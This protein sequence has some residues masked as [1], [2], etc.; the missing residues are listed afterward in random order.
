MFKNSLIA[1]S[2][3]RVLGVN[4]SVLIGCAFTGTL[5][6][7]VAGAQTALE[8]TCSSG[9]VCRENSTMLPL[10]ALPRPYSPMYKS[11]EVKEGNILTANVKPFSPVYVFAR[12]NV[13]FSNPAEP[14]GWYQVGATVKQPL[15]WIQAKDL[16]E[17]KQALVVSYT[18][19]GASDEDKRSRVLMFDNK[20]AL[21]K[22]VAASD[23]Q[24]VAQ[25]L[26][27]QITK[28]EKPENVITAEPKEFLNIENTFY[29]LPVIDYKIETQF[30][31]ETRLL[32]IAAAVPGQRSS[33]G[34]ETTLAN[35]TFLSESAGSD[36][37]VVHGDV[38][39]ELKVDIVF[40][41]DMTNSMGPYIDLTKQAVADITKTI[42]T[43]PEV[44]KSVQFGI[45]GYRDNVG[46]MPELEF[47]AKN[48][49]PDLL[50]GN[51]FV[52]FV[53]K[54]VKAATVGSNDYQEEVF[55]GVVEALNTTKWRDGLRFV[56]IVGDASSHEPDHP[57]T[58]T[59]LDAQRVRSLLDESN[60]YVAAIHLQD[61]R[62]NPDWP[63]AEMQLSA[64]ATNKGT[65]ESLVVRINVENQDDFKKGVE[66]VGG[67]FGQLI[68]MA[69]S[70]SLDPSKIAQG[71]LPE[72][73][74]I[75]TNL[76]TSTSSTDSSSAQSSA[77]QQASNPELDKFS[78]GLDKAIA[79]A[80]I[81]YLGSKE[82]KPP[83]DVT[84]WVMDRDLIDPRK[85][86]M[87]VRL[88]ISR[89]DLN[90]LIMAVERVSEALATAELTQMKFFESLKAIVT[91]GVK[92]TG[93]NFDKAQVLSEAKT[94]EQKLLPRWIEGL[95][96]KSAIQ[97]M[98]DEKFEAM[99]P[100]QRADLD[101]SLKAKLQ[102]Y[103]DISEKVDAWVALN[104]ADIDSN[105]GKVYP[106]KLE[107][108][109]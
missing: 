22:V 46:L 43:D 6:S 34:K 21:E 102:Y 91:Q 19:P 1:S 107:D 84:A 45:V 26:Y 59:K 72:L 83:R 101:K 20:D 109:P 32:Q 25:K 92:G 13:D 10:K 49:T 74:E 16:M 99:T 73:P 63:L 79:A 94:D 24:E 82:G 51:N 97:D 17:W 50:E 100:D 29:L 12:E 3:R 23:R 35:P 89:D 9:N 30:D 11:A 62:A 103:K 90:S 64:M 95:P 52:A 4:R 78:E 42:I 33:P 75:S 81:D 36:T 44:S 76:A 60:A 67:K 47:T 70:G 5:I 61:Q 65:S 8:I 77:S 41:M 2:I 37:S 66:Q 88:L 56:V 80:L 93:I 69:K 104:E 53:D 55:A 27:D 28:G 18:H 105:T 15:G 98:S 58:T 38:A 106:L 40:V 108:L 39:K 54:E 87:D 7:G 14:T 85:K 57:Q 71:G 31:D 86:A 68:A 48:F 96:Y